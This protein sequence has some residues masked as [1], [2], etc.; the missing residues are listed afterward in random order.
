MD[1]ARPNVA[2]EKRRK[3]IIIGVVAALVLVAITVALSRLKPAA[4][5]VEKNLV[6][7]DVVKRGQ[8][9]RQVRGLGTLVPEEI[10]WIAARTSGRV[11]KIVLRPGAQVT[12]DSVILI[13][14]NPDVEQSAASADSQLKAAEADLV[15]TRVQL[16]SGILLAES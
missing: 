7:M 8:M 2:K 6:W 3:R 13:L 12:H 16:E 14:A 4:P 15:G 5:P 1:I 10:R 11:D 9:L